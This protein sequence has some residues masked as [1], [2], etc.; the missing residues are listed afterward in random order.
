MLSG[1][2]PAS[3]A[4]VTSDTSPAP[5]SGALLEPARLLRP[6]SFMLV[7]TSAVTVLT[8][9]AP[10]EF[11]RYD[12]QFWLIAAL[13]LA[14]GALGLWWSQQHRG[15]SR[16]GMHCISLALS[17]ILLWMSWLTMPDIG[18]VNAFFMLVPMVISASIGPWQWVVALLVAQ[19]SGYA[20]VLSTSADSAGFD[21]FSQWQVVTVG[22]FVTALFQGMVRRRLE[23]AHAQL[24][25][26]VQQLQVANQTLDTFSHTLAHDLRTPLTTIGGFARALNDVLEDA[27]DRVLEMTSHIEQSATRMHALIEDVLALAT[28]SRAIERANVDPAAIVR[29]AAATVPTVDVELGWMPDELAANRAS[30][31]R[32]FQNLLE[33]AAAYAVEQDGRVRVAVS[34]EELPWCWRF[35]VRDHGPGI[36][37]DERAQVFDAFQRGAGAASSTGTGLGLS[38]V[39]AC[40]AAHAGRVRVE[41]ASG[42][43]AQFVLELGRPGRAVTKSLPSPAG[44]D[45]T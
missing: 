18:G 37:Q 33:N 12:D 16:I 27:D 11:T 8:I 43:G 6:V 40:A 28:V 30:L 45:A 9:F 25:I 38:I 13:L 24:A 31:Y 21:K 10:H 15:V 39:A 17:A 32:C 23:S 20:L 36:P 34:A 4:R 1:V 14:G 42:G 22:L 35:V 26:Q 41:D 7:A 29:E 19:S 2:G 3:E 44:I 5:P